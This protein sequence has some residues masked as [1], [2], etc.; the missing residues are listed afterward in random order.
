MDE[1]LRCRLKKKRQ[2]L[3]Y[4]YSLF[5]YLLFLFFF[6]LFSMQWVVVPLYI[7]FFP[8][9]KRLP[10]SNIQQGGCCAATLVLL[11]KGC[12]YCE[13]RPQGRKEARQVIISYRIIRDSNSRYQIECFDF[14]ICLPLDSC[15]HCPWANS[16]QQEQPLTL[17]IQKALETLT[18]QWTTYIRYF[19]V[20]P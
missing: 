8:L 13:K 16:H 2:S 1:D 17:R 5:K 11:K 14:C 12:C 4:C 3:G 6:S 19:F 20:V 18:Y 15:L 9:V 10:I 7:Q